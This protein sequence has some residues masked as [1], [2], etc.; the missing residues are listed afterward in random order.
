LLEPSSI[1]L[2]YTLAEAYH[3]KGMTKNAISTFDEVVVSDSTQSDSLSLIAL[4]TLAK[5]Y[6]R[7]DRLEES[8]LAYKQT[9][10]RETRQERIL[11]I[12]N[13]LAELDLTEGKYQDDGNT[14]YNECEEVIGGVGPGDMRTNQNFEIARHTSDWKKKEVFFKKAIETDPGMHQAYFNAGLALTKQGK[15]QEA[16]SYF[17]K[18]NE[19]WKSR[20]DVNP[21]GEE[22]NSAFTYL[23]LCY[24]EL[25][26]LAKALSFCNR[27]IDLDPSNYYAHLFKAKI[28]IKLSRTKEAI[29]ILQTLLETNPDDSDVF[30]FLS[31]I[32][33]PTKPSCI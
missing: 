28:L 16:I 5:L 6:G 21:N 8:R 29:S 18:S 1:R 10:K 25:G 11:F 24:Y 9:L 33:K 13:Q 23:G 27:A 30:D 26:Q 14:I 7:N 15:F 17:Q 20:K 22:K 2:T 4:E 31:E 12:K 19:V 3:K 32:Q